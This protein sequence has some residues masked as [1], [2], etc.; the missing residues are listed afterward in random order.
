MPW[1]SLGRTYSKSSAVRA[2]YKDSPY[3]LPPL[4]STGHMAMD[5]DPLALG[6][7]VFYLRGTQGNVCPPL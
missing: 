4:L 3:V 7:N 2:Q 1:G 5:V 6:S